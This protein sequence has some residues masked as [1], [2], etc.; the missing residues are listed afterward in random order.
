LLQSRVSTCANHAGK[1]LCRNNITIVN[2]DHIVNYVIIF[3]C[4]SLPDNKGACVA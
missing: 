2:S 3:D 4:V 1:V